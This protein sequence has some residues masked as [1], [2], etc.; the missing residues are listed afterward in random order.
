MLRSVHEGKL[1]VRFSNSGILLISKMR[2][3]ATLALRRD[4]TDHVRRLA[5]RTIARKMDTLSCPDLYL[6]TKGTSQKILLFL[7]LCPSFLLMP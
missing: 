1:I 7:F 4:S 5:A 3:M 2:G 6:Q